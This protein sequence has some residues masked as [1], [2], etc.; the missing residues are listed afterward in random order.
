MSLPRFI[1]GAAA[2]ALVIAILPAAS[3]AQSGRRTACNDG[4]TIT[5]AGSNACDGH[6]G[7]NKARTTVINRAPLK[8]TESTRVAQAGTPA[9]EKHAKAQYEERRGWRWQRH[10]DEHRR[11]EKEARVRCRDGRYESAQGKGK[12]VCK[13]HRGVAH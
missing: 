9:P 1:V 11:A 3:H 10:R 2:A 8:H 7:V 13:H 6:G 4:S 12:E 5:A